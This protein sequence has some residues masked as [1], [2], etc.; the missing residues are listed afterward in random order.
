M[1]A[2]RALLAS[3][4]VNQRVAVQAAYVAIT[5]LTR[6]ARHM[7]YFPMVTVNSI[8]SRHEYRRFSRE[9]SLSVSS[10]T[11][12]YSL[13]NFGGNSIRP[14]WFARS[15]VFKIS[16]RFLARYNHLITSGSF[17]RA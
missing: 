5:H 7:R 11:L 9:S 1:C 13:A 2:K 8:V 12:M 16:K 4:R 17:T 3:Q 6:T 10:M 15:P 14:C